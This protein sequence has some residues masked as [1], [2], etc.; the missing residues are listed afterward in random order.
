MS[1]LFDLSISH[2]QIGL[3]AHLASPWLATG[4]WPLWGNVQ[5]HYDQRRID[6]DDLLASLPRLGR[7][8]PFGAGY[9]FTTG[10]RPPVG[11]GD[12]VRL[13]I[14]AAIVLPEMR[15][16]AGEPFIRVLRHMIDLYTSK[17]SSSTEVSKAYLRSEELTLAIPGL[18]ST[19]I[20]ALPDLLSYEPAISSGNGTSRP[21]GT[22]ER[23][24][25]RSV[26]QF[27]DVT[28]LEEYLDKT[29]EIVH[30]NAPDYSGTSGH[31]SGFSFGQ[32]PAQI[33]PAASGTT[34]R[35]A[36]VAADLLEDLVEAGAKSTWK[37]H[38][39]VALCQGLNDAYAAGNPYV[40]A[41]MIRAILDH[42]PPLFGHTSFDQVA[43]Q[44]RFAMQK[45][46]KAHAKVLAGSRVIGD[47]VMHRPIGPSVPAISMGDIPEPVR[48]SAV[49]H[50]VLTLLRKNTL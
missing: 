50:E 38:K 39:L 11:E 32:V 7:E 29:T 47:D 35:G 18:T 4:E 30:V 16:M 34:D 48:L 49:L 45:T 10:I 31:I 22:W 8:T 6:A 44:H 41:A 15:M 3:L 40:C 13:T 19:F 9:G 26:L 20:Q 17:P 5:H 21:D 1:T 28:T 37:V 24:I 25:T 33:A 43:A 2:Q 36:Y 23:E 46:D 42:I 12:R 14:A 27:R